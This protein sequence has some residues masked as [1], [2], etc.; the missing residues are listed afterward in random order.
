MNIMMSPYLIP[1]IYLL[2]SL[3]L[4]LIEKIDSNKNI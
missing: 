4:A 3:I 2:Q 1:I